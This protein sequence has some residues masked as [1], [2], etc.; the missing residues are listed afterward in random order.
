MGVLYV[1]GQGP[2]AGSTALCAA[3]ATAW[4]RA[5]RRVALLKPA[6]L[7][8][9]GAADAELFASIA[10]S[11]GPVQHPTV[12]TGPELERSVADGAAK[13]VEALGREAD[14]VLVEGLPLAGADGAPLAA[15]VSLAERLDAQVL[16]VVP[17]APGLSAESTA[18]WREAFGAAM[19]GLLVNRR[20]RYA[21][22]DATARLTPE[23]QEAGLPVVGVVPEE[24]LLLAPTVRQ[25]ADHLQAQF[26]LWESKDHLWESKDQSLVEHFLIGGLVLEWGVNYFDRFPNQ[27]VIVQSQRP[28]IAMASLSCPLSCL[29]LTGGGEPAQYT[30]QLA[31]DEEVPLMVVEGDTHATAEALGSVQQRASVHHPQKV[32][33]FAELLTD[34]L[35][36]TAIERAAGLQ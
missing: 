17:Y 22:H 13:A 18:M 32:E 3:L 23:L 30:Y 21:E 27:A 12:V 1:C 14:V 24:R 29:I 28:D 9:T 20:T 15:S 25:V 11:H 31:D 10:N 16:G 7:G 35:D 19:A 33:R 8:E 6:A 36:W 5:G 34:R 26:Y 2:G 4:R